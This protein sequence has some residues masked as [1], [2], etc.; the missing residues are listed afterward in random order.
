[1]RDS[2]VDSE[3]TRTESRH[4]L[5][6]SRHWQREAHDIILSSPASTS[7]VLA[8]ILVSCCFRNFLEG[9][10]ACGIHLL[11]GIDIEG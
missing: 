6:L 1:M 7:T 3:D 2:G 10:S 5:M 8:S 4:H 11:H 9:H